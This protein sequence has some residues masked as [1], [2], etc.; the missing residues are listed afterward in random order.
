MMLTGD[1][2]ILTRAGQAKRETERAKI[3][4]N[5]KLDILAQIT[6]NKGENP[7][8]NQIKDI[9]RKYFNTD[10]VN[11]IDLGDNLSTATTELTTLDG[12]HKVKISEV[13]NGKIQ[14]LEAGIYDAVAGALIKSWNE[15]IQLDIIKVENGV[16]SAGTN[17]DRVSI[18]TGRIIF[19]NDITEFAEGVFSSCTG[20]TGKIELP[21]GL[22]TIGDGAFYECSGLTG[23][24]IIPDS[25]TSIGKSAFYKCTGFDGSLK[26]S[27][28]VNIIQY[29][30]FYGCRNF[31]GNLVIPDSVTEIQD[32]SFYECSNFV[33]DLIITNNVTSIGFGAFYG[34]SKLD[35]RLIVPN[36]VTSLGE[37]SFNNC[38]SGTT[39]GFKS[40]EIDVKNI[41]ASTF[42]NVKSKS[43]IIGNN[44]LTIAEGAFSSN[45]AL[46]GELVIGN[47]V[48]TIGAG[49]FISCSNL[50]GNLVIPNN[51]TTIGSAAFQNCSGFT[52]NL[53]IGN[54]VRTIETGAFSGCN[55]L[56]GKIVIPN[57]VTSL[58]GGC[59]AGCG[60]ETS[61]GLESIEI[62]MTTIPTTNSPNA[63]YNI[64]A[65]KLVLGNN[66]KTIAEKAF[67]PISGIAG[68]LII[69]YNVTEISTWAFAGC[70]GLEKIIIQN[71]TATVGNDAFGGVADV[72]YSGSDTNA[73]W[74]AN[75]LNGV[76]Q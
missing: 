15:L 41:P 31:T 27:N 5:V 38:S 52:E 48:K 17:S 24:L 37:F 29:S 76:A 49:A 8:E 39:N 26:I 66:V 16:V 46:K 7:T 22:I 42:V 2:G 43:L 10:E 57:S 12:I 18:L 30:T 25:V 59:F 56:S 1:N 68:E 54:S 11:G 4:E 65:Q 23:N 50:T 28:S 20:L 69:P 13:Y 14:P 73:P 62:D 35:G 3:I 34:C 61:K 67:N 71:S 36:S 53:I 60:S 75:K 6:E 9:L 40:M 55:K 33:G 63:F 70:S 64:K 74:G 47:S 72:Y 21:D 58:G 44:V 32:Q 45:S 51:V 19:P